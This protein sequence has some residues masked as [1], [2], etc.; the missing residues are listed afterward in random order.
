MN[1]YFY[2]FIIKIFIWFLI[3]CVVCLESSW[4]AIGRCDSTLH[5]PGEPCPQVLLWPYW[6]CGQGT[7]VYTGCDY[8]ERRSTV[9]GV[10]GGVMCM[11][12]WCVCVEYI[13]AVVMW[14]AWES[15]VW[16]CESVQCMWVE[17]FDWL[18]RLWWFINLYCVPVATHSVWECDR[19]CVLCE[20]V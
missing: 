11:C 4:N 17:I 16:G 14:R 6:L 13:S 7:R 10:C 3:V 5:I 19:Q 1:Y 2:C 12:G 8:Q 9:S 15:W 18:M 20:D